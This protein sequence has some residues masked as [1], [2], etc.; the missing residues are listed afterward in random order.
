[1]IEGDTYLSVGVLKKSSTD[2]HQKQLNYDSN[3]QTNKYV[4]SGNY[5]SQFGLTV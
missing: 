4:Q 1:M 2:P 3:T 5:L